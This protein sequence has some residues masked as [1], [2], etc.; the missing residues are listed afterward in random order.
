M[1]AFRHEMSYKA[2]KLRMGGPV[3]HV[4]GD[5]RPSRRGRRIVEIACAIHAEAAKLPPTN[6]EKHRRCRQG[7][8]PLLRCGRKER[9]QRTPR[10]SRN[11]KSSENDMIRCRTA[12][13]ANRFPGRTG[14]KTFDNSEET[15]SFTP[16]LTPEK[17]PERTKPAPFVSSMY[18]RN[19]RMVQAVQDTY[20]SRDFQIFREN[21]VLSAPPWLCVTFVQLDQKINSS[22]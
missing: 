18:E 15:L 1:L 8:A 4:V 19:H 5:Q 7:I 13:T 17:K 11:R 6:N 22:E 21:S 14:W 16:P 3:R 2:R 9:M 10:G 12:A 20:N